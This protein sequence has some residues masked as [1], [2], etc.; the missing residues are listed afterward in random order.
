MSSSTLSFPER[1]ESSA[2]ERC[3]SSSSNRYFATFNSLCDRKSSIPR[4]REESGWSTTRRQTSN[5]GWR[6]AVRADQKSKFRWVM[7]TPLSLSLPRLRRTHRQTQTNITQ[8]VINGRLRCQI[9]I[10]ANLFASQYIFPARTHRANDEFV[11][12]SGSN[13]EYWTD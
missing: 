10:F 9:F 4:A 1:R 5:N 8:G 11:S 7:R 6:G 13:K 3:L 12:A 2:L